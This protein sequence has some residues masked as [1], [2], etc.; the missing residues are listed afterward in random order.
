[1]K[2]FIVTSLVTDVQCFYSAQS[3]NIQRDTMSYTDTVSGNKENPL[4]F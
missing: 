4:V 3:A 1:M 2:D